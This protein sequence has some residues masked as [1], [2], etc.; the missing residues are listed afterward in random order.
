[1]RVLVT[2]VCGQL[3]SVVV[4]HLALLPEVECITGIDVVEPKQALP[5]QVQFVKM[6]VRSPDLAKVMVGHDTIIHTAFVVLWPARMPAVVRDDINLNG[7]RN[8]AKSAAANRVRRFVH[9]SSTAAYDPNLLP[10]KTNLTEDFPIGTGDGAFYYSNGKAI[11]ERLVTGILGASGTMLTLLRPVP[12]VGPSSAQSLRTVRDTAAKILWHN[13]RVQF[14]HEDD[15]ATAFVQAARSE[16]PGAYNIAP[17]DFIRDRDIWK[18]LGMKWVPPM[19]WFVMAQY[20]RVRWQ[21]FGAMTHPKWLGARMADSTVSNAKLKATG[22]KPRY[23]TAEALRSA[24]KSP[25]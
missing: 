22:W 13:P 2:G 16:M 1:M 6:D 10:G 14:A 18:L 4:R 23:G 25:S 5:S 9:A 8:V 11:A 19:H 15:V 20:I 24:A 7:T 3:G 12:I 17:D 21:Y